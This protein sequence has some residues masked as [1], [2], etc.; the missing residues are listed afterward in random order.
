MIILNILLIS[1]FIS[2]IFLIVIRS[3]KY[4]EFKQFYSTESKIRIIEVLIPSL[5]I[6][7]YLGLNIIVLQR[8]GSI[9]TIL[10]SLSRII[11]ILLNFFILGEKINLKILVLVPII[12][13][14]LGL[15]TYESLKI[16]NKF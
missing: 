14:L 16:N 13:I 11:T 10:L 12:V 4:K 15:V 1:G 8:F 5:I 9:I 3:F 6:I 7:T 2:L